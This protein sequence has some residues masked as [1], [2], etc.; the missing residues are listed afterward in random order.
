M[1]VLRFCPSGG[2][3]KD[4]CFVRG[5]LLELESWRK[6]EGEGFVCNCELVE[7]RIRTISIH[8]SNIN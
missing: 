6:E 4:G 2:E 7:E 3:R 5:G 8:I 1:S